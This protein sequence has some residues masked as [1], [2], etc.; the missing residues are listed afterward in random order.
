M[1]KIRK[2][3][4]HDNPRGEITAS[5]ILQR[6]HSRK[7]FDVS[8]YFKPKITQTLSCPKLINLVPL[9][10]EALRYYNL[11][12]IKSSTQYSKGFRSR[13]REVLD[14]I[15]LKSVKNTQ[16]EF[17]ISPLLRE[18]I[19]SSKHVKAKYSN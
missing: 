5:K 18:K 4:Y 19:N 6:I 1:L 2:E 3:L 7:G 11:W 14:K 12:E 16:I 17:Q 8:E 9:K 13:P 15:K 10:S